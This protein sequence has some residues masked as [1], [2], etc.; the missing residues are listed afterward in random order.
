MARPQR[1]EGKRIEETNAFVEP[2]RVPEPIQATNDPMFDAATTQRDYSNGTDVIKT[3]VIPDSIPEPDKFNRVV[4]FSATE[5]SEDGQQFNTETNQEERGGGM[6][7]QDF[8]DKDKKQQ[9]I[10]TKNLAESL[11]DGLKFTYTTLSSTFAKDEAKLRF[12]S[13]QGKFNIAVLD[14][15]VDLG[16]GNSV[17]VRD[18]LEYFNNNVKE[19][20]ILNPDK[21]KEMRSLLRLIL[22]DHGMGLSNEMRFAILI[23]QDILEKTIALYGLVGTMNAILANQEKILNG[24]AKS[25]HVVNTV[26]N[27]PIAEPINSEFKEKGE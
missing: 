18:F 20:M 14:T 1:E 13:A 24:K 26:S 8:A 10:E 12:K 15:V 3:G 6:V 2:T 22:Q 21:E 19:A 7:D 4:D 5:I 25:P 9:N 17:T 27:A 16:G 11:I 23:G